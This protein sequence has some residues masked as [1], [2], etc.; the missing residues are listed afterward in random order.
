MK[1]FQVCALLWQHAA[2]FPEHTHISSTFLVHSV[3]G[4][5]LAPDHKQVQIWQLYSN[6]N[7]QMW[8]LYSNA[9]CQRMC[10][11]PLWEGGL[12]ETEGESAGGW[13]QMHH[14]P[15]RIPWCVSKHTHPVPGILYV[16]TWWRATW[17]WWASPWVS[18]QWELKKMV[19][20][21]IS[22]E[23]N[24]CAFAHCCISS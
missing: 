22:V 18:T 14:S 6:A 2:H 17:W 9:N 7:C 4:G 20:Y 5:S 15:P 8:Q 16:F 11:L 24:I 1:L 21:I 3:A 13:W 23:I 10:V 12:P 19:I